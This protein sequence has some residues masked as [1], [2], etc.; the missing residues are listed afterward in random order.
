MGHGGSV[1]AGRPRMR[2]PGCS[3]RWSIRR[4]SIDTDD[5]YAGNVEVIRLIRFAALTGA[6]FASRDG[7]SQTSSCD[8]PQT[9]MEQTACARP[10]LRKAEEDMRLAFAKALRAF[11]RDSD[12]QKA[13]LRQP[14][15][16]E[17]E[18][19][20][21]GKKMRRDVGASQRAWL[22]YRETTCMAVKDSYESGTMAGPATLL[23]KAD[24]AR[25][26]TAFLLK[27]FGDDR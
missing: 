11:R 26:R 17:G 10:E 13:T 18:Q 8:A 14:E 23:C 4:G 1:A 25:E 5:V 22:V 27:N 2:L 6:F 7:S 15:S 12:E 9:T 21:Y 3:G 24:M 20:R 16:D 19:A